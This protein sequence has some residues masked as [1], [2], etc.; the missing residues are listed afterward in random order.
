[1]GFLRWPPGPRGRG[2]GRSPRGPAAGGSP[3]EGSRGAPAAGCRAGFG[4]ALAGRAPRAG[5]PRP[6]LPPRPPCPPGPRPRDAP[7]SMPRFLSLHERPVVAL[8]SPRLL[9]S[10]ERL[11]PRGPCGGGTGGGVVG[12]VPGAPPTRAPR[13]PGRLGGVSRRR[14]GASESKVGSDRVRFPTV[15]VAPRAV[16]G[17]SRSPSRRAHTLPVES[18]PP[19]PPRLSIIPSSSDIVSRVPRLGQPPPRVSRAARNFGRCRGQGPQ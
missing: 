2:G 9:G 17:A 18:S 11:R 7:R 13:P 4:P 16:P 12:A 5:S 19:T 15:E 14:W 3:A 6:P 1:M 8:C 10:R